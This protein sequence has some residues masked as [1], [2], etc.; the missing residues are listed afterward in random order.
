MASLLVCIWY[1][2]AIPDISQYHVSSPKLKPRSDP[3]EFLPQAEA[4][5]W[6]RARRLPMYPYRQGRRKIYDLLLIN[7][8]LEFLEVRLGQMYD[9]V[10]Y[11]VIVEADKTFTD[12][13]KPLFVRENWQR[14]KKY[15]HKMILHT[16]DM[17]G[18][19]FPDTWSR[20]RFSRNA[21]YDQ[22]IPQLTGSQ[23]ANQG[24]VLLVSDVDEIPRPDALTTLRNCD[25]PDEVTLHT[26]MYYYGFQWRKRE[27]WAHPQATFYNGEK[28]VLPQALRSTGNAKAHLFHA[29]WHCSYCFSTLDEMIK[30]VTSFSHSEMNQDR[31]KDQQ[32]IVNRVRSGTDMFDRAEEHFDR[33]E[34]NLDVPEFVV[35]HRDRYAYLLDRDG[36][37]GGFVDYEPAEG[38]DNE[39]P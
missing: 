27:D 32:L 34:D 24:D 5:R 36:P 15:H 22:V 31:F 25:I 23:E 30:K 14:F 3:L 8:E 20:E 26:T 39:E 17:D 4:K 6:C 28:T 19:D 9:H 21:M 16:L 33:I 18:V 37:N 7:T 1:F 35:K 10:D 13:D 11:F 29:G 2:F 12:E 38:G